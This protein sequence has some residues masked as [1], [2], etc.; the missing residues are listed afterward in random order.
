MTKEE[1]FYVVYA[2]DDNDRIICC[3]NIHEVAK[4]LGIKEDSVRFRTTTTYR[5]RLAKSHNKKFKRK[6]T[7]IAI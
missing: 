5:K 1:K 2:D 7:I 4:Y 6:Q 3:G